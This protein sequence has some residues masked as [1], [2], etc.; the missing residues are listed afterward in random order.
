M[1]KRKREIARMGEVRLRRKRGRE[2]E[3]RQA[4]LTRGSVCVR[5]RKRFEKGDQR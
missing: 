4:R 3:G 5:E 1:N 2:K